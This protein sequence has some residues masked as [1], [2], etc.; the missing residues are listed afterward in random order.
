MS[1]LSN[2]Q[3]FFQKYD[4]TNDQATLVVKLDKFLNSNDSNC[5]LLKGYAGTGKTFITKGVTEYLNEIRRNYIL[6]APTGKAAKVIQEKTNSKAHTIHKTIYSDKDLKE[7]QTDEDGKT[8]KFY[9]EL[10]VNDKSNDTVYIF[11]EASMISNVYSEMEFIRFGS[12]FLLQDLFKYINLDNNDHNKKI[13]FIGDNAQLPPVGMGFSP[14]LNTKYLQENFRVRPEKFELTN[15]V[16]QKEDSGILKNSIDIRQTLNKKIFNHLEI[17]TTSSDI[18]SIEHANF[19][20]KYLEVTNNRIDKNTMVIAYTNASVKDYNQAIRANFFDNIDQVNIKDKIMILSNNSSG[21]IFL[22]N[23]DFGLITK[24]FS[25]TEHKK[26]RLKRKNNETNEVE[27]IDI[28]LYFRDIELLVRDI[29]GTLHKIDYKIIENLLFSEQANLS[30]D[31][32]KAIY[33]DF[34]MRNSHLKANT[35]EWKDALTTDSYFNALKVKFGYAITC[36]KAQGSEWENIFLNCKSHQSYLSEG[37]FRWLYTAL[38]RASKNL[39]TLDEPHIGITDNINNSS[40]HMEHINDSFIQDEAVENNTS[41][42]NP[43]NIQDKLLLAIYQKIAA[44]VESNNIKILDLQHNQNQEQYI[45]ESNDE[46]S[47]VAIYYNA[48][49]IITTINPMEVNNL[50]NLL[51]AIL[52]PLKNHVLTIENHTEFIF[53]EN[54]LE[55]FYL[56]LKDKLGDKNITIANI[57]HLNYMERY[58]FSR[59]SEIAII[60]FYYNGNGQFRAPT[61]N[62]RSNSRQLIQDVL[63]TI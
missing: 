38:T 1:N 46:Q 58:S 55:D 41:A 29:Y 42:T 53:N 40:I 20:N 15:V 49:D 56:S 26:V 17:D 50:S 30:S 31:E 14:A 2:L 54:F 11:D 39:Y 5:F 63:G 33:L 57:E 59:N 9:F 3:S 19:I 12:G 7:Y 22:S 61:P 23:G 44:I 34:V 47:R 25:E 51:K 28:D 24:I 48:R 21:G 10:A 36:H 32:T 16:R 60:D 52:E 35:K 62:N 4:L 37:Y 18:E 27:N 13:I 43:F 6:A 45:F 8:I